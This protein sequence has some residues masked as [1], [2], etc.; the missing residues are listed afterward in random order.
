M[1]DDD[2]L[3]L[4]LIFVLGFFI[5]RINRGNGFSFD[6][7]EKKCTPRTPDEIL[8]K[9]SKN[10]GAITYNEKNGTKYFNGTLL[11]EYDCFDISTFTESESDFN[12]DTWEDRDGGNFSGMSA[13]QSASFC[14]PAFKNCL[15]VTKG[16][17]LYNDCYDLGMICG[18]PTMKWPYPHYCERVWRTPY[19]GYPEY[20]DTDCLRLCE[21]DQLINRKHPKCIV[22]DK[23]QESPV[24]EEKIKELRN[25]PRF[26]PERR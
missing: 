4:I 24:N 13:S 7:N 11:P 23:I 2:I 9:I 21:P 25:D 12:D 15:S 22:K 19:R 16:D 1:Q 17:P 14:L 3:M 18:N 6:K 5:S 8:E 10:P 26:F 20:Q